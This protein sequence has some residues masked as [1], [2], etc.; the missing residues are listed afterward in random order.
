MSL[1]H[2][3]ADRRLLTEYVADREVKGLLRF[4]R[5]VD[6][7][8][9]RDGVPIA[10]WKIPRHQGFHGRSSRPP[11]LGGPAQRAL[12]RR[13]TID[14]DDNWCSSHE[15]FATFLLGYPR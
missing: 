4:L 5:E 8:V 2:S 6:I 11:V 13:G 3:S 1:C 7:L 14:A 12:G 10:G 9:D 15:V